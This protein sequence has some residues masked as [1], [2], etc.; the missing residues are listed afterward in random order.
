MGNMKLSSIG[1]KLIMSITGLFLVLFLAFHMCMNLVLVFSAESYNAVCEFLGANWYAVIG[2]L[3]LAAGVL[4]HFIFATIL[5]VDNFKARGSQ[6]YAVTVKE[7]NVEWSS[8]NMYILGAVII[9]GLLLHLANFWSKMQLVE[10]ANLTPGAFDPTD[11]A[12]IVKHAFSNPVIVILYIV[13][14]VALWFHLTHGVWSLFH[15]AGLNN[16][17]WMKALR[18]IAN[19]VSTLLVAGFIAV[20]LV[21]FFTQ[22]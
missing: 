9:L 11:G 10:L 4:L 18:C 20:V 13:W 8:K 6:R 15:T 14:L 5:T 19:I 22:L 7:D 17:R 1:K 12:G 21:L 3:V 16:R 2:T